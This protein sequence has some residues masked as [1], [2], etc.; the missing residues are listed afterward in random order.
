MRS[1]TSLAKLGCRFVTRESSQTF[2]GNYMHRKLMMGA[3]ASVAFMLPTL[4]AT[5]SARAADSIIGSW[6][7]VSWV[8]EETESKA[9][10]KN[11][12]DNPVGVLTYGA[13]GRM[14]II[15]ADPKRTAPA[16]P[17]ATDA[18]AAALYRSMVAYAGS[19]RL[20]GDKVLVKVDVSWN[21]V[22]DGQDRPPTTVEVKADR[23]TYKTAPFVSPFL[24]KQMVATL[25][26]D[27][28]K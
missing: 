24:G 10:H 23:L 16:S 17:K 19:Y 26:W 7:L 3:L 18:E 4:G 1:P 5:N 11:F 14:S 20:E 12:G 27:R 13:D 15:F 21:K 6:R 8:E 9:L 28:I 22:W 2:G 25:V